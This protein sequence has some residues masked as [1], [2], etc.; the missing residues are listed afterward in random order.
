MPDV[1]T[2]KAWESVLARMKQHK[3][4]R[5]QRAM[6]DTESLQVLTY[7]QTHSKQE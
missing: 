2:A 6:S 3:Q 1:H 4:E 5:G 7:L